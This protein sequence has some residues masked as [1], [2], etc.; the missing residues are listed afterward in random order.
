MPVKAQE[1]PLF[2]N[3]VLWMLAAGALGS[4]L[5]L[6]VQQTMGQVTLPAQLTQALVASGAFEGPMARRLAWLIHFGVSFQYATLYAIPLQLPP[7]AG[8][9]QKR[10][11]LGGVLALL[12][13]VGA[14]AIAPW[15]M[16][17]VAALLSGKG[18]GH[19]RPADIAFGAVLVPHLFL[20]GLCWLL[21]AVAPTVVR[22]HQQGEGLTVRT[23]FIW[24][25]VLSLLTVVLLGLVWPA[26][27]LVMFLVLP[28]VLLGVWDMTQTHHSIQR[29][30]PVIGH[31]RY[32]M[33]AVRPEI[34]QYFVESDLSGR[35]FSRDHRSVVYQ[36]AKGVNDTEPFGTQRDLYAP[37][38]QWINHSLRALTV[39]HTPPRV[40]FGGD[41]CDQPYAA[42][43][44][45]VSAMSYGALSENAIQALNEGARLGGFAHNTGEGGLSAHHLK[46]GGD[47]IWQIGTGYFGCRTPEGCF[48]PA[49]FAQKARQP[50]V[51][52]IEIKLSQGA[53][54]GHG[55]ILPAK[56]VT[57]EI[58]AIRGVPLGQDV[59]SPPTHSAFGSPLELMAFI[60]QLR[61]ESGG[62]PVGFKLC[63]GHRRE[64]LALIKAMLQTGEHP[65]FIT[66]DGGEGGTGAAP[67]EFAN[68]VG[69]PLDDGLVF[70][71]SAL[72]GAGL[73]KKVRLI[74]S[75]KVVTGFHLINKLA[76]GADTVNSAR[77]MMMALG[78]IQARKC[79]TNECP[80]GVATQN[81]S[82]M[83]G[84]VVVDKASRVAS[85]QQ[86]T[87]HAA[88]EILAAAGLSHPGEL[89]PAHLHRRIGPLQS[90]S[91]DQ[92]YDF[93]PQGALLGPVD[94]LPES[95]RE[96]WSR[97]SADAF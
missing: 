58:A 8:R 35:P 4:V 15:G 57:A 49:A 67:L 36:R 31:L 11:V 22:G 50:Q 6:A 7:L 52:M 68:S 46:N 44:L 78:C 81:P 21:I 69:T 79:N 85:F 30:F 83:K 34:Q 18:L 89:T 43:I 61:Q 97:A 75:G 65:D 77:A 42:A 19:V 33:E 74:A 47:L 87:V 5:V 66:V 88:L 92:L 48:D 95:V 9:Y 54:P 63:L 73:R 26:A 64:F 80:V 38:Y 45:N 13:G 3:N 72:V 71:H 59:L 84:L 41:T 53:K 23:T 82:L 51:K 91:L 90:R 60:S 28:V 94:A 86:K 93:L 96:D 25:S 32:L 10:M 70:V 62:K 55:G 1:V 56:K 24:V 40:L 37:G 17:V 12:L 29:N 39:P 76:L 2:Q 27:W 14:A 20:F 16:G